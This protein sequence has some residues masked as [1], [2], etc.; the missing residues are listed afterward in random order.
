MSHLKNW[1]SFI[2]KVSK[3]EGLS[4]KDAMVRAK[5]R[6]D[7]GEEWMKSSRS[8]KGGKKGDDLSGAMP[9]NSEPTEQAKPAS[10]PDQPIQWPKVS[11]PIASASDA[12]SGG[13][14]IKR[15]MTKASRKSKRGTQRKR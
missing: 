9:S 2:K 15:K 13:K 11:A 5:E 14:M 12:K 1:V 6:Q 10:S 4:Y 8:K 3:E 7:K